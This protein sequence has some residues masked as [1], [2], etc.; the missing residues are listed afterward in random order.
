MVKIQVS[1]VEE[2]LYQRIQATALK[3]ERSLEGEIRLALH[4]YYQPNVKKEP[5]LSARERWQLET[6]KRLEWLF[7]VLM[8]DFFFREFSGSGPEEI[9]ELVGLARMLNTSPGLLMDLMEG[10]QEL[11]F[12]LA[13]TMAQDLKV[14]ARWLLG[15]QGI[16]FPT[17]NLASDY[18][19]FFLSEDEDGHNA[20]EFIRIAGG[21]HSGALL[22]L[23]TN[24]H[25][26]DIKL[27]VVTTK[28]MPCNVSAGET[29]HSNL[30]SFLLFL[31]NRCS[32]LAI[33][34]CDWEPEEPGIEF[35]SIIGQHHPVYFQD[36]IQRINIGWLH[37]LL[38]GP[39]PADWFEGWGT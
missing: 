20:F 5:I 14:S 33:Q 9:F 30:L 8:A 29:G 19:D 15:G 13:D 34:S 1:N 22:C 24:S 23:R 6:G 28:F 7:E 38:T 4:K 31:K 10:L 36:F 3:H 35:W 21:R 37:H 26:G 12:A 18:S 27:G 25:S 32:H 2:S 17:V 11:T 39:D 16:P